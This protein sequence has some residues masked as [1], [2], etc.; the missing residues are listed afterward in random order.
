MSTTHGLEISDRTRFKSH[1]RSLPTNE[2]FSFGFVRMIETFG[3]KK[4]ISITQMEDIFVGVAEGN[5]CSTNHVDIVFMLV[6]FSH[7]LT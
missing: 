4:L 3:W 6:I 5:A 2:H 1:F 7:R